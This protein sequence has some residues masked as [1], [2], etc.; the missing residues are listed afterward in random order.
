M[1]YRGYVGS[2]VI[3]V[4]ALHAAIL[5]GNSEEILW[6]LV[7]QTALKKG[8]DVRWIAV[9][10]WKDPIPN[11]CTWLCNDHFVSGC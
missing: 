3:N 2:D 1:L 4:H 6:L 9:V 7:V 8:S 5:S 10:G 11:E